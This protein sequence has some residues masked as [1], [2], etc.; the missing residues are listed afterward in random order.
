MTELTTHALGV[1]GAG[2]PLLLIGSPMGAGGFVT[3]PTTG[4][5]A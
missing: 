1:P 2:P 5:P 3:R 4:C